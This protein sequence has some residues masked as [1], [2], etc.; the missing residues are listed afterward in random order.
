MALRDLNV[1]VQEALAELSPRLRVVIVLR[2]LEGLSYADIA[3]ILHCS[4]GTVKSRLNRAHTA[5]R[6]ELSER[7]DS[8]SA[9]AKPA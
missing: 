4:L 6:S 9:G 7:Y 1:H 5:M 3:E 8:G 2:Y